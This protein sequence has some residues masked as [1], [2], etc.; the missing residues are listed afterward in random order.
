MQKTLML[1]ILFPVYNEKQRL[2]KGI[3]TTENYLSKTR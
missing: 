1:N 3:I 2:E